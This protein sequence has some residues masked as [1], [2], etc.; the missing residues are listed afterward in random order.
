MP[1]PCWSIAVARPRYRYMPKQGAFQGDVM[2][3]SNRSLCKPP[4][5]GIG[6]LGISRRAEA[7]REPP[8]DLNP[9][10]SLLSRFVP[11]LFFTRHTTHPRNAA[12]VGWMDSERGGEGGE[13]GGTRKKGNEDETAQPGRPQLGHLDQSHEGDFVHVKSSHPHAPTGGRTH[14]PAARLDSEPLPSTVTCNASSL[15]YDGDL[16]PLPARNA[17]I[18]FPVLDSSG[19]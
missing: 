17:S 3:L 1:E 12:V 4:A 2:C 15:E 11:S 19:P 9:S 5:E 7:S 16:H 6:Y 18:R 14:A 13:G 10:P 8:I